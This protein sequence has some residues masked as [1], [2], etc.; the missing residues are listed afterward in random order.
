MTQEYNIQNLEKFLRENEIPKIKANPKTFLGIAKQPHYENVLSNIY[1]FYFNPNEEHGLNDLFI[2]SFVEVINE[3]RKKE[4]KQKFIFSNDFDI[5]R[6][7]PTI[8]DKETGKKGRIDLL[9]I[10]N[11]SSIIIE[12][13]VYHNQ[14]NPFQEYW[15]TIKVS[16]KI[17]ILLSLKKTKPKNINFIN[18]THLEFLNIIMKNSGDYLLNA[19]DKYIIF[20]KDLY[21]NIINLSNQMETKDIN[22]YYNHQ[23]ELNDIA[24]LKFAVRDH[25][26]KEVEL[27]CETINIEL[28]TQKLSSSKPRG[29]NGK[30]LR[31]YNSK[32]NNDLM[33]TVIFDD[34]LVSKKKILIIVEMK[35]N[36]LNDRNRY[37]KISFDNKELDIIKKDFYTGTKDWAHFAIECYDIKSE[38]IKNL[39]RVIVDKL[40]GSKLIS[41]FGKLETF[42]INNKL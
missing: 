3:I 14:K 35:N 21:Q 37:E 15:D 27:A 34:L 12:N 9:L 40:K 22:F 32:I 30:R 42:L 41:I 36:L 23:E 2:K 29:E 24:K 33:F 5:E 7:F 39:S 11:D 16:N 13:K 26:A 8:P 25:I 10:N 19:S 20:L 4:G 1:A 28:K 17:G 31:Y 18:I 6:E 38:E